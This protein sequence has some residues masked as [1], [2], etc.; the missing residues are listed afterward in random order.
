MKAFLATHKDRDYLTD[1]RKQRIDVS[2][3][4]G[5]EIRDML[6]RMAAVSPEVIQRYLA[7]A[8][9]TKPEGGGTVE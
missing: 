2:P 4:D 8:A 3:I 9:K 6:E 5:N 1:A 7:I